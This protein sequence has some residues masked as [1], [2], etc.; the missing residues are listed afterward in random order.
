MNKV[1]RDVNRRRADHTLSLWWH[2]ACATIQRVTAGPRAT[3]KERA[4]AKGTGHGANADRDPSELEGA[5][6]GATQEGTGER[7][8]AGAMAVIHGEDPRA[9]VDPPDEPVVNG[10]KGDDRKT[11]IPIEQIRTGEVP[12]S[13]PRGG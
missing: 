3:G 12:K 9:A 1:N 4:M 2:H 8:M 6:L 7:T 13:P 11:E 10:Y 5:W